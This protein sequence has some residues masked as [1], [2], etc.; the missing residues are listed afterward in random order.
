VV[1]DEGRQILAVLG[2]ISGV[3]MVDGEK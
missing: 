1:K 2:Q 3:N